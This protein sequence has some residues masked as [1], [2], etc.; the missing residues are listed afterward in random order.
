MDQ[1][2]MGWKRVGLAGEE[3]KKETNLG[4]M[5]GVW[6]G[7]GIRVYSDWVVSDMDGKEDGTSPEMRTANCPGPGST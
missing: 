2:E 3:R 7:D 5:E 4:R 6:K 1:Y